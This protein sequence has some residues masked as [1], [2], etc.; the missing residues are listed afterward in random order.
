MIMAALI[1]AGKQGVTALRHAGGT[2]THTHAYA[3]TFQLGIV[4][5]TGL[6]SIS[7]TMTGRGASA[8]HVPLGYS[9][10]F[11]HPAAIGLRRGGGNGS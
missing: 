1:D 4:S 9:A 5:H 7:L 11:P 6:S 2:H 3:H 8:H 10:T